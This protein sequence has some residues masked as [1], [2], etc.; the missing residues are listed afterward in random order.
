MFQNGVLFKAM[1]LKSM[2]CRIKDDDHLDYRFIMQLQFPNMNVIPLV[3]KPYVD[4]VI[5][6]GQNLS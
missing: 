1:F 6:T 4:G 2:N 5:L 3:N